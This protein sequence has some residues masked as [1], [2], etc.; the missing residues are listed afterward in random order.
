MGRRVL[1]LSRADWVPRRSLGG[2]HLGL[3]RRT[4]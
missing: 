2:V 4:V 3:I 1:S